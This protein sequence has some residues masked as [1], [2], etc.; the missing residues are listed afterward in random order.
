MELSPQTPDVST[1]LNMPWK[2]GLVLET[3]EL[4]SGIRSALLEIGATPVLEFS[5]ATSSFEIAGAVEKQR[6]DILF[7]ELARTDRP[8]A[9]WMSD[10]RRGGEMPLVIAVHATADPAEM[11]SALR[12]GASE[13]V[14]L[15]V[16]PTIFEALERIAAQL[17]SRQA[18]TQEP[19][20]ILGFLSAKGGCGATSIA[21]HLGAAL[22]NSSNPPSR[23]LVADL[24]Y[25]A[26]GAHH[27]LRV[28]PR[29]HTGEAFEA[30]R[31]LSSSSWR[32]F[33]TQGAPADLLAA[34]RISSGTLPEP[35]RVESLLRFVSRQYRWVLV[36][37]G[38]HLNPAN[39]MFLQHIHELCIVTAPE[40]LALYQ[41]R[42]VLQTLASRGLDKSH[43]RLILNRNRTTPQD[44]WVESIEQMFEMNVYAVIPNDYSTLDKLPRDRFEFPADTPFGKAVTKLAGRLNG[45]GTQR[46]AA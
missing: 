20:T 29:A 21:C 6:P 23:V 5:A 14:C 39:W 32:E 36:D 37:L 7:V 11:I 46:K 45:S 17:E 38:R 34:P 42:T 15:P 4:S 27:V 16:R 24:D 43:I 35:W 19:G 25:Q 10:V 31:R 1:Q 33:A 2:I 9:E 30:V 13:F 3:P 26:P 12:S 44:F 8:A 41:T 28:K 22:H 40:V 18:A